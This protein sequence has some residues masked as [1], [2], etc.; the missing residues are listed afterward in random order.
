ML[1]K[2]S[3]SNFIWTIRFNVLHLHYPMV[4]RQGQWFLF[5]KVFTVSEKWAWATRSRAPSKRQRDSSWTSA[6]WTST[7]TQEVK[8]WP[9]SHTAWHDRETAHEIILQ[10]LYWSTWHCTCSAIPEK[11]HCDVILHLHSRC[12]LWLPHLKLSSAHHV[13]Y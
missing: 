3:L 8:V 13:F 4:L 5:L 10:D 11:S 9:L 7:Q 1:F 6:P 2:N 12:S